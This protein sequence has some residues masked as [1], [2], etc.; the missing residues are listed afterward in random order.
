[1]AGSGLVKRL[2]PADPRQLD[3]TTLHARVR[4]QHTTQRTRAKVCKTLQFTTQRCY[5]NDGTCI[6]P[7]LA[8]TEQVYLADYRQATRLHFQHP[9]FINPGNSP[10]LGKYPHLEFSRAQPL[11]PQGQ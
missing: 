3:I 7:R 1:M 9:R 11:Q 10:G 4:K 8:I 5:R 6:N 2:S